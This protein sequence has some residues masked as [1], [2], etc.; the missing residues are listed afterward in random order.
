MTV[1]LY[2]VLL[3][4]AHHV[5]TLL[6]LETELLHSL[7]LHVFAISTWC[8]RV[9][10]MYHEPLTSQDQMDRSLYLQLRH[11]ARMLLVAGRH[12]C[13]PAVVGH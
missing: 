3:G 10:G 11:C 7:H 4:Q 12:K 13:W 9:N 2:C 1:S 5:P 8:V 6:Q